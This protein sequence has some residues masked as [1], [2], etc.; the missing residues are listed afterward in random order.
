[1][2]LT[3]HSINIAKKEQVSRFVHYGFEHRSLARVRKAFISLRDAFAS[4]L[5]WVMLR[6]LWVFVY[7]MMKIFLG[8]VYFKPF[9]SLRHRFVT[10]YRSHYKKIRKRYAIQSTRGLLS[11]FS[12]AAISSKPCVRWPLSAFS[13]AA[14]SLRICASGATV[15]DAQRNILVFT[16]TLS[17]SPC[18]EG[19]PKLRQTPDRVGAQGIYF[20]TSSSGHDYNR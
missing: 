6:K 13:D 18:K 5:S 17:N 14:I 1:M 16:S 20:V 2:A 9:I 19:K 10:C 11:A 8:P 12:D 15:S 3:C 7:L 4:L